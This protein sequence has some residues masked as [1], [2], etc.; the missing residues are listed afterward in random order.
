L[1]LAPVGE[2]SRVEGELAL[3]AGSSAEAL[4]RAG[5]GLHG[6]EGAGVRGFGCGAGGSCVG[7][8]PPPG[9]RA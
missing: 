5:R 4:G 1:R 8:T 6:G 3:W 7:V 9:G 2:G